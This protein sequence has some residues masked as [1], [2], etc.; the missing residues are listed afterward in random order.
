MGDLISEFEVETVGELRKHL[1]SLPYEMPVT[2]AV[3]E[4]LCIRIYDI[5]GV[6]TME[7]A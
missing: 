2:D 1:A 5:D 7:V 3:G 6:A 4:L